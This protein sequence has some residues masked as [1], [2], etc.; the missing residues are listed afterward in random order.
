PFAARAAL[1]LV[2]AVDDDQAA[3]ALEG[4]AEG[5]GRPH[6]LGP[7]VDQSVPDRRVVSPEGNQTPAQFDQSPSLAVIPQRQQVLCGRD[8]VPWA[9]T[10]RRRVPEGAPEVFSGD[11]ECR[12]AA[13]RGSTSGSRFADL[14]MR[15]AAHLLYP[16]S[17]KPIPP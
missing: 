16:A 13:H 9:I 6:G 17:G 14:C 2:E 10:R 15:S 7:C 12:T 8:V 1:P 3:T 5:R 11:R 4:V